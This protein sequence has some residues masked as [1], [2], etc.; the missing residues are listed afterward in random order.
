MNWNENGRI[1]FTSPRVGV[2]CSNGQP[3]HWVAIA[4]SWWKAKPDQPYSLLTREEAKTIIAMAEAV[5]PG[6]KA[7]PL[8]GGEANIDRFMD[9]LLLTMGELNASLLRLLINAIDNSALLSGKGSFQALQLRKD[10]R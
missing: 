8:D 9:E 7:S 3:Q 2:D 6:G 1:D 10:N 4:I 5:F